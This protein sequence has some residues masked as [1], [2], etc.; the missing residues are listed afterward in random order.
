VHV[1]EGRRPP[2]WK[3][4]LTKR[5]RAS[6]TILIDAPVAQCQRFFTPAGEE[7]WIDDWRPTYLCPEDGRTEPGMVFTTGTG[8]D[9]TI[10]TVV[11][12]D[13]ER[14]VA[15][16][17]RVTPATRCGMVEIRCTP[18]GDRSTRVTV[19]YTLTALTVAGEKVLEA[20]EG[21]A[22]VAMIEQWKTLIDARLPQLLNASIR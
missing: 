1:C 15:R 22:F 2:R 9:H 4:A 7:A 19:T 8:D 3:L 14:H 11:D 6:H 17:A 21:P 5:S 18:M 13:T 16:Y 10:W 12:F 20:F